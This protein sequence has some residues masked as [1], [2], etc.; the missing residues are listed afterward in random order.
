[1]T[2]LVRGDQIEQDP[3]LRFYQEDE[4][5]TRADRTVREL[6]VG[7][8]SREESL[9]LVILSEEAVP[10]TCEYS[11]R[12]RQDFGTSY[13]SWTAVEMVRTRDQNSLEG[14]ALLSLSSVRTLQPPRSEAYEAMLASEEVLRRDWEGPEEDAAWA[15]L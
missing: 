1:M 9:V 11:G 6:R 7:Q 5:G 4:D 2:E 10:G 12:G 3:G 8:E 13:V 15:H 14:E